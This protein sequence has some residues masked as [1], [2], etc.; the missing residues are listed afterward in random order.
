MHK[1]GER[2][3]SIRSNPALYQPFKPVLEA[4]TWLKLFLHDALRY[5]LLV[6]HAPSYC[7]KTEW[8]HSLFE[9]PLELKV[10]TLQH[11]PEAMRRFD[12]DKFDGLILDDVRDVIFLSEHQEK[13]QGKY[14]GPVEFASTPGGQ[15]AYW[16]DLFRVP[17][18]V[19]VNDS[20]KNLDLLKPGAHDFLGKAEN[21]YYLRFSGRPGE[22]PPS[23]V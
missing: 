3:K 8:A 17:V 6:A 13:L 4:Q 20:T 22:V 5:P 14:S 10:G 1:N 9:R 18:V 16:R 19:T 23:P 21:V 11:F 7:G 2:V 12:K 15:C